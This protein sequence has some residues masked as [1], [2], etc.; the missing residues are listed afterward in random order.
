[1]I[2]GNNLYISNYC[3]SIKWY[4]TNGIANGSK[5]N[6]MI[7]VRDEL[8][9]NYGESMRIEFQKWILFL[10]ASV[11]S[12]CGYTDFTALHSKGMTAD[13][14]IAAAGD[15]ACDPADSNYNAGA[16]TQ[17]ACHMKATSDLL[18]E[19]NP[20]AVLTLGDNQYEV[21]TLDE[22][23]QSFDPTWGRL[24]SII[25][26]AV[27]NHEYKT[28]GASGYFNY[29]RAAA[30]DPERGY[31]S[32][33]IGTWHIIALNSN[34]S[35]IGGCG[36][37]SPQERWLRAD[38]AANPAFC[39]LAYWHHPRFSSGRYGNNPEYEAFWQDL[40]NAGADVVLVGHEHNY[41]RFAPQ[42]PTGV[43]D[44]VRGIRQFI[45]GTG[46][47][48][49]SPFVNVQTNSE[50]RNSDTFGVLVITLHPNGYD[51]RFVPEPGKRFTDSGSALCH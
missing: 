34:C 10:L 20:V 40:Y 38:L 50:V 29:F 30:G 6:R 32:Y 4:F 36:F 23:K 43:A 22:F 14:V 42:D 24:K 35:E 46:G 17:T 11:F 9:L 8:R 3:K 26:P 41:E 45:V 19:I 44:P 16:G 5:Q 28:P 15:I 1:M 39:T 18:L 47:K 21:A 51:W 27:G 31:Y 2:K 49:F 37:G 7:F 13:P 33:N 12:G 25:H 48:N